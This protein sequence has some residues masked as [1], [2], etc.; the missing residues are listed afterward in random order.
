VADETEG[1]SFFTLYATDWEVF[2]EES[3]EICPEWKPG[4]TSL[5]WNSLLMKDE[6]FA[7]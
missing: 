4:Q 1:F 6:A 7:K 5:P 2:W 3:I